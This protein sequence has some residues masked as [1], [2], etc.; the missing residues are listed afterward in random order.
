MRR[1]GDFLDDRKKVPTF[2]GSSVNWSLLSHGA[3]GEGLHPAS[4]FLT[5]PILQPRLGRRAARHDFFD[6]DQALNDFPEKDAWQARAEGRPTAGIPR[7]MLADI[8]ERVIFGKVRDAMVPRR[9]Q[10]E[11]GRALLGLS[12][13]V[14]RAT[15]TKLQDRRCSIRFGLASP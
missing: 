15:R 5:A 3:G 11:I 8:L 2:L 4:K 13:I 14:R 9:V 6:I 1:P 10:A 12:R 7:S